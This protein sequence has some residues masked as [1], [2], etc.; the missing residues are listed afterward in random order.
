MYF[1]DYIKTYSSVNKKGK[2][3]QAFVESFK[4]VLFALNTALN[5][6]IAELKENIEKTNE[7]Y[8]YCQTIS[9]MESDNE[10]HVEYKQ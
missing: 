10:L 3:I 1:V 8:P 9:L 4:Q 5:R 7:L 6:F 2:E